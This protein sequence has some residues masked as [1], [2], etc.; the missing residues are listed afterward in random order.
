MLGRLF[1][2]FLIVPVIE[3]YVLIKIGGYIGAVNTVLLVIGTA[4][5]GV[6]LTR[7]EGMRT[8]RQ[9]SQSLSQGIVPAEEMIDGLL[10]FAGGI[11]LLTPGVITD[12][13]ALWLLIPF[14][15][16]LF[17]R[18]LRRRFDRMVSSGNIQLHYRGRGPNDP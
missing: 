13:L 5:L 12:V 15:R 10:I 3:L 17:K 6:I 9:I 14:T 16:T 7:L 8:L 1:L 4:L 18:W 2:L 11:L